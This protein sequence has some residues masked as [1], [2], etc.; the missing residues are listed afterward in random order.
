MNTDIS[1][2]YGNDK[3]RT[4]DCINCKRNINLYTFKEDIRLSIIAPE[5]IE[6]RDVVICDFWWSNE[7]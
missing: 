4:T 6:V 5:L 7:C 1:F 3:V 2:C